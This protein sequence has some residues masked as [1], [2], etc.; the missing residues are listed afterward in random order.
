MNTEDGS[1]VTLVVD[2]DV[3]TISLNR[4]KVRNALNRQ[5]M[6]DVIAIAEAVADREDIRAVVFSAKGS[7]FSVG[8]D[9]KE[10]SGM[11]PTGSLLRARRDAELGRKMLTA[12]RNI[13]Q[14]TICAVQGI[15]TGGG[16][17][18]AAACDFG[19]PLTL[20][21]LASA[22]KNGHELNV[23]RGAFVCRARGSVTRQATHHVRRFVWRGDI[24]SL[25][26]G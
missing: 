16:A 15:A 8:A 13:H 17:C 9:L 20:R 23:E 25:G 21:V 11:E 3:A 24:G 5:L 7:D 6:V 18:I 2:G 4:P 26:L 10:V 19:L 22:S 12:I 1:L 14:P